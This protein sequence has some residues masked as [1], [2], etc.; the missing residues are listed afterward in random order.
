VAESFYSFVG[1]EGSGADLFQ[2]AAKLILIH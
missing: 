2:K 1:A